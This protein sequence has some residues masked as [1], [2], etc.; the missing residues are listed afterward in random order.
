MNLMDYSYN[1]MVPIPLFN[2]ALIQNYIPAVHYV[3]AY[4][5]YFN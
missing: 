1:M 3:T 2:I 5:N 4:N